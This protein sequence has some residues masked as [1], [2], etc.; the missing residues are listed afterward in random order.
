MTKWLIWLI[1]WLI[2]LNYGS[3]KVLDPF[4][5]QI[6]WQ[7]FARSTDRSDVVPGPRWPCR[8]GVFGE[9][10]GAPGLGL[11]RTWHRRTADADVLDVDVDLFG[12]RWTRSWCEKMWQVFGS[13][14][15]WQG[16][17][18][19]SCD[20]WSGPQQ[21]WMRHQY[22]C[23]Q[24]ISTLWISMNSGGGDWMHSVYL[25][26]LGGLEII[27]FERPHSK[28]HTVHQYIHTPR[29]FGITYRHQWNAF[30]FRVRWQQ[31]FLWWFT[32]WILNIIKQHSY[33]FYIVLHHFQGLISPCV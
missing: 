29:S 10:R 13:C 21:T 25:V 27:Q 24:R 16:N 3:K 5:S 14:K 8:F 17:F 15:V 2:W 1:L 6:T 18:S 20:V 9:D 11:H 19:K 7:V 31:K 33:V 23:T 32:V 12:S 30:T 28:G 22:L 26:D 4:S